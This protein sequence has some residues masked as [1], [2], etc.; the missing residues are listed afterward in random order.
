MVLVWC[1]PTVLNKLVII[2]VSVQMEQQVFLKINSRK[3]M[4]MIDIGNHCEI[5]T[6]PCSSNPCRNNGTCSISSNNYSCQCI[7]PYDG[8]HCES[9][10]N[11][12]ASNPCLNNGKCVQDSNTKNGSYRCEYGEPKREEYSSDLI[13]G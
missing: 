9:V 13:F 5:E 11:V 8:V 6:N 10:V 12:C 2:R 3:C 1:H 7:P 4:M